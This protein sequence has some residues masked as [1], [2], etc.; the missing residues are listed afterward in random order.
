VLLK[1]FDVYLQL[2]VEELQELWKGII[3]YD[4]L[5]LVGSMSLTLRGV[6]LW[7][8]CGFLGYGIVVGVS[9]QGYIITT[10]ALGS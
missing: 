2:V 5:K 1:N 10:R 3:A 6:L 7:T 8:M 4:M 9:H